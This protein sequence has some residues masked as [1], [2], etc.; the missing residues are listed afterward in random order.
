[1]VDNEQCFP[2]PS[3]AQFQKIQERKYDFSFPHCIK[4][5][6]PC[7]KPLRGKNAMN[8]EH[9]KSSGN[10]AKAL[11][12]IQ[13]SENNNCINTKA[14]F[15]NNTWL[16]NKSK[17]HTVPKLI[18]KLLYINNAK[19]KAK[20]INRKKSMSFI[21]FFLKKNMTPRECCWLFI[22]ETLQK[23]H[24][25]KIKLKCWTLGCQNW[26]LASREAKLQALVSRCCVA[27]SILCLSLRWPS[28]HCLQSISPQ[29][30]WICS[31]PSYGRAVPTDN[32]M[33]EVHAIRMTI[34]GYVWNF[35]KGLCSRMLLNY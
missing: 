13:V 23:I 33:L 1:M 5:N 2:L 18:I 29:Y 27:G 6:F 16:E 25:K 34:H 7:L 26:E 24:Y 10:N 30:M 9:S 17:L 14:I 21:T 8:L 4:N 20:V 19:N 11:P 12:Q 28:I 32:L 22:D 15:P 35:H 31:S 3:S